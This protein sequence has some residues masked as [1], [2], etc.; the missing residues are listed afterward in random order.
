MILAITMLSE[1]V[2]N[3]A[4]VASLQCVWQLPNYVALEA[5][6]TIS[7]W[8]YFSIATVLLGFPWAHA[9]QVSWLSRNAGSV[10]TRTV[11][12]SVYNMSVQ[13]AALIGANIYQANDKPRYHKANRGMIGLLVFNILFLYPGAW[14]Y[15]TWRNKQKSKIWDAWTDEEK[16]HYLKTTT[17]KGNKRL[18]FQFAK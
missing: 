13:V 11:S 18:D 17:D 6:K 3:R 15:Y 4:F 9:L 1:V 7:P 10:R 12:A 14:L 2:D 16:D 8:Q 5:L